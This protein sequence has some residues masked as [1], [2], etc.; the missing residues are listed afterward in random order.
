MAD[1]LMEYQDTNDLAPTQHE[2]NEAGLAIQERYQPT[3]ITPSSYEP[4]PPPATYEKRLLNVYP[5]TC[6][7]LNRLTYPR[8]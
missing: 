1:E 4:A 6:K 5:K 2:V 3:E 7:G 8:K